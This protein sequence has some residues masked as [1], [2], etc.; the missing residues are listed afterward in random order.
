MLGAV[1]GSTRRHNLG[2]GIHKPSQE[3]SVF[4]INGINIIGAKVAVFFSWLN[5]LH[6]N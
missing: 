5:W 1:A 3:L 6:S 2:L 4:V